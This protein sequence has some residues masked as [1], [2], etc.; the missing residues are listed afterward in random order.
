VES[1][2]QSKADIDRLLDVGADAFLI[3]EHFVTANDPVSA[4]RGLL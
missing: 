4:L 3:G 2:I 1:G